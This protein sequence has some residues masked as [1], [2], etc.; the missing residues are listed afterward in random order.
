MVRGE[1]S[2]RKE[3]KRWLS[4]P[5]T[6]PGSQ[7]DL[8]KAIANPTRRQIL[9]VLHEVEEAR[10]PNEL[11]KALGVTVGYVSYHVKVLKDCGVVALTDSRPVRGAVER[12]YI[13]TVVS[14]RLVIAFLMTTEIEDESL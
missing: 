4:N 12:F 10:S 1:R 9:R 5:P 11:R 6:Y 7:H 2:Q 13:S 8:L 14:D 3:P